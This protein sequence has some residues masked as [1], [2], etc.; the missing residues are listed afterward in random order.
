MVPIVV[1]IITNRLWDARI[2]NKCNET[3]QKTK[4]IFTLN[5]LKWTRRF[6]DK[7]QVQFE[8]FTL[9][10]K[11]RNRHSSTM[12]SFWIYLFVI[13]FSCFV[14][15]VVVD[16]CFVF[17]FCSF[18]RPFD[19]VTSL[20]SLN[21]SQFW[22]AMNNNL[23]NTQLFGRSNCRIIFWK[24]M[25][26]RS[27]WFA[28]KTQNIFQHSLKTCE[29]RK[30]TRCS[31]KFISIFQSKNSEW[32]VFFIEHKTQRE[33]GKH[34][35][36]YPVF[37]NRETLGPF[38]LWLLVTAVSEKRNSDVLLHYC[39]WDNKRRIHIKTEAKK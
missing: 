37:I 17:S 22:Y 6:G 1:D 5:E 10:H 38:L 27:I 3:K 26:L 18:E 30:P 28:Y 20:W 16:I 29:K 23:L 11:H 32:I 19:Y 8:S 21:L 24:M 25:K 2:H 7:R 14:S 33:F 4:S 35:S 12:K 15:F 36:L 13:I 9:T 39:L 34:P 31:N